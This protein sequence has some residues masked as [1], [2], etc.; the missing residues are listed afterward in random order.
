MVDPPESFRMCFCFIVLS[1][2]LTPQYIQ[3]QFYF[4]DLLFKQILVAT[5]SR[6]GVGLKEPK[7]SSI[8]G[9]LVKPKSGIGKQRFDCH[10]LCHV[11]D[12]KYKVY[13]GVPTKEIYVYTVY[14][15]YIMNVI[16]T[17]I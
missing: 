14:S 16:V 11:L 5:S 9:L 8:Q 10:I 15:I 17:K 2:I 7:D 4:R 6:P 13:H 12:G 1:W 3:A